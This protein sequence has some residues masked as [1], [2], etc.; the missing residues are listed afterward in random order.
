[1]IFTAENILLI[2]AILIFCA[3]MISKTG[4]RFGIPTLLLFLLVGMGFGTDG[5][6][7]EFDSAEDAQFIGMIALSIILFTGGMDTKLRDIKPVMAQGMILSTVGVLLT[8]LLTGGFI[9]WLSG[10]SSMNIAM[11]ILTSLLLAATMSST[12]SASVFNLLRS[13]RMNLKENLKPMLELESG[14]NDPMAY[15]LTIALIQVI[16]SGSGFDIGLLVKD[17]LVQFFVGGVMG[18]AFGR[19]AVWLINKVN[20]SNSSLYPILLL[21]LVFITFTI[22]DLLHGNGYLAVY[23]LG[24]IVG[25]ARLVFRKEINTFMNGLTW[26]SQIVMF[27]SLGLLVNPHEMLGVSVCAMLIGL[28]MIFVAR[29]LTVMLCLLPFRQMTFKAKCFVSWVGLRGAV[30]IIFATYPVVSEIPGSQVIFNIVFFITLLSLIFQGMTI[31]PVAKWLSL[32]L[33]EEKEGNE[34]G[35]EI[36]E[37]IDSQLTDVT[38]T[39]EMLED[40]NRLMDMNIAPGTLVMLVKRGSEF[41]IPNGRMELKVGDKLL[42]ISENKKEE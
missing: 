41:M 12:D 31:A 8:T 21:S 28:F 20:L 29:P 37:E 14:S 27:L 35:V 23:I 18:Y 6:G 40:G 36:P 32:D 38:L 26:F 30:P 3:I 42:Y 33:P 25:N 24:V 13:Q 17:L 34:F 9:F 16:A 39:P 5:L 10:F 1:M 7:L 11:P 2:G 15:M 4:Y 22:T 19:L